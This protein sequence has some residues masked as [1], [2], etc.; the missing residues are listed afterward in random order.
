MSCA[1]W[2]NAFGTTYEEKAR[3]CRGCDDCNDNPPLRDDENGFR[4]TPDIENR[5]V[6][7][8]ENIRLEQQTFPNFNFTDLDYVECELL[9]IWIQQEK[10]YENRHQSNLAILIKSLLQQNG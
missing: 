9:K 1:R 10:L 8:I 7:N 2:R 6:A 5:I 4:L 3:A